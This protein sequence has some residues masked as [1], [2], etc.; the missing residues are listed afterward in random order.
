[1]K[2]YRNVLIITLG[3]APAIVTETVYALLRPTADEA[4]EVARPWIPNEI[5]IV[6]TTKGR[7]DSQSV[8]VGYDCELAQ[9]C[10]S[11]GVPYVQP[12]FLVP[13]LKATGAEVEDIRTRDENVAYANGLT[14]L[15]EAKARPSDT[16]LHVSLAG[17]RKTMSSYAHAALSLFGRAQD[18]LSHVLIEPSDLEGAASRFFWPGQA[19]RVLV[20]KGQPF[21]PI[22]A[23]IQMVRSPF[24]PLGDYLRR[25]PFPMGEIDYARMIDHAKAAF[26][27]I[28]VRID[29]RR[30]SVTLGNV[31]AELGDQEFAFFRVLATARAER[32]SEYGPGGAGENQGGWVA[33]RQFLDTDSI[34]YKRFFE[35]WSA[36]YVGL[37]SQVF[38]TFKS[39]LDALLA[40]LK[41]LEH[42]PGPRKPEK[43]K[44]T[45]KA[46]QD[47]FKSIKKRTS[48]SLEST[49]GASKSAAQILPKVVHYRRDDGVKGWAVGIEAEPAAIK[50][51]P[52]EINA[53]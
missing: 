1:M 48:R 24:V 41:S 46:A 3:Q 7:T 31:S 51:K 50:F 36:C 29:T 11:V 42:G 18:E 33:Y 40:E 9:L 12:E 14:R 8:V 35:Y 13:R 37:P 28:D 34:A 45:R 20:I 4:Q 47:M 30:Q 2:N 21:D 39:A 19:D 10:R 44:A 26:A 27:L 22:D 53:T 43:I 17:G 5:H 32:W 25:H 15:I 49:F 23:T 38:D 16:Q 6:T 52:L